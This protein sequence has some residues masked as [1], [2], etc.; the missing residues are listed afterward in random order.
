MNIFPTHIPFHRLVDLAEDRLHPEER[1]QLQAHLAACERCSR[2]ADKIARL[3]ALMRGDASQ[4][5]PQ[6]VIAQAV[7]LFARSKYARLAFANAKP[8]HPARLGFDSLGFAPA[9]GVRSGGASARQLLYHS[10]SG[11]I[12]LRIE[13]VDKGWVFSGQVLGEFIAGGKVELQSAELVSQTML[14]EQ[15]EFTFAPVP[16]GIYQLVIEL[17]D[18][19]V[20]IG[21]IE[22]GS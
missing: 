2:E 19:A 5:A 3:I 21:D 9:F 10:E 17:A 11:D 6:P 22:V 14:D 12:D 1:E 20:E 13:P 16:A 15:S 18:Y 8:R 4:D 7:D